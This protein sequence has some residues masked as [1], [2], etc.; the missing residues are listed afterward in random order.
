M[1]G[2]GVIEELWQEH[3]I[4][5]RQL[6]LLDG[7][8]QALREGAPLDARFLVDTVDLFRSFADGWHHAREER[9]LI[10]L[11]RAAGV[12][13]ADPVI[14]KVLGDHEQ[15]RSCLALLMTAATRMGQGSS[16]ASL[17]AIGAAGSY[18]GLLRRHVYMEDREFYPLAAEALSPAAHAELVARFCAEEVRLG[19]A[20][21]DRC[22]ELA[23]SLDRRLAAARQEP[24]RGSLVL[25]R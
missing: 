13:A 12:S 3:R 6:D 10:P 18:A 25:L 19:S 11:L 5:E 8:C 16:Y 4:I 21:P 1:K 2:A 7:A 14:A 9:Q 17:D 15:A 22:R 20:V 23:E 24:R